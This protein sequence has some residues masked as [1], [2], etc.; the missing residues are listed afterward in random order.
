MSQTSHQQY[1]LTTLQAIENLI[2][3]QQYPQARSKIENELN[4]PYCPAWVETKLFKYLQKMPPVSRL[5]LDLATP[6]IEALVQRLSKISD[7]ELALSC[8]HDIAQFNLRQ[9]LPLIEKL[10][11]DPQ[12]ARAIKTHLLLVL[13]AQAITE[14]VKWYHDGIIST[15]EQPAILPQ[16][17]ETPFVYNILQLL[18]EHLGHS[19]VALYNLCLQI[20]RLM[21]DET[22]PVGKPLLNANLATATIL[23]VGQKMQ[24]FKPELQKNGQ[25][26][27][28]NPD[29]LAK[30]IVE[31]SELISKK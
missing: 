16:F 10:L 24:G 28:I 25:K 31:F 29:N 9:H 17:N 22:F 30:N 2:Q 20:L 12:L 3:Q 4:V 23:S 6:N 11:L 26:F 19:D 8:V 21:F 13:S 27:Q 18:D 15:I 7:P 5:G 14:P 1:Y